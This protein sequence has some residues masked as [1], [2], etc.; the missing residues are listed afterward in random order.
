MYR[1]SRFSLSTFRTFAAYTRNMSTVNQY[2]ADTK[3]PIYRLEARPFF[4]TLTESEKRYAHF[5]SRAAF[6]GTRIAITQ[7]NPEAEEIYDLILSIFT[8]QQEELVDLEQ[9]AE[10]SGVSPESFDSLLQYSAQF[11]GNLSNYKSFGD[12]KFIPRIPVEDFEK[13]VKATGSVKIHQLF[14]KK[15]EEIYSVEPVAKNL[16]GYP[17]NGN[18]S[19]Y[20]TKNITNEDICLVQ[21]Y[22]E[23]INI[24]SLNTRLFKT[25]E[26]YQIHIASS[27]GRVAPQ[28][29]TLDNGVTLT[30]IYNDF[31]ASMAKIAENIK[32]AIRF[33]ANDTQKHMLEAYHESFVT[34]SIEAH[35]ESQRHW[36]KDISP[37]VETNVGF[38]ETYRDPHGVRA[39]WEGFVAM[40]NKEQTKKFNN[41]VNQAPLF[42]SRLPWSSLFE[43]ET[44]NK[45]DFTSLEVLSFATCGIPSGINIPNY[46]NI[47]QVLGSK[48]VSLGNVLS[49]HSPTEVYP[50]IREQDLELYRKYQGVSFEVQVGTHELGHGT[51]KLFEE[52]GEGKLNF[53]QKDVIHP[54]TG[55]PIQS[56]YK[57]GQTF[58]SIFKS[59]ASSYE[60]CRA[61]CI[62]LALSPYPDILKIF[63]L[64]GQEAEDVLYIMYLNMARAG[65]VALECYNPESKQWNQA[66]MQAR[67]AILKV[68]LEAGQ[69]FVEIKPVATQ[70]GESLEIHLD[71]SK[72]QSVG[73]P[74]VREFLN[75]L[76][77]FK[78]TADEVEGTKLYMQNTSVSSEWIHVRD[79][80]LSVKQPRKVFVQ[81]NTFIENGVAVFKEYEPTPAGMIQS[82]IERRV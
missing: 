15:L 3:T 16:I 9:L 35:M 60:E 7:T 69:S 64:E 39:E 33:V 66:H 14:I 47:T 73:A 65:L 79:V 56:W 26:G 11:L 6:H 25:S 5:M 32:G 38:I 80:V 68:M 58:N 71:R 70:S 30:I 23:K 48:N 77:I 52:D 74:A 59:I 45:P 27:S 55:S 36:L 10:K 43:R 50:L 29:H 42:V 2:L 61:E 1:V 12:E 57:P 41:L 82:F 13:V 78:A 20:Y 19:G 72:I 40:V 31:Q 76:Q 34:G 67:Y 81:G 21:K 46:S 53:V 24:S 37:Q 54:L 8:N 51:G 4:E 63:N 62:A 17:E 22:L 18:I 44:L 28:L 49:A 75:K